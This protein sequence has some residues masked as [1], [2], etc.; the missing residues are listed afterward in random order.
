[1]LHLGAEIHAAPESRRERYEFLD[2][3]TLEFSEE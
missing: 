3:C 1:V 2:T